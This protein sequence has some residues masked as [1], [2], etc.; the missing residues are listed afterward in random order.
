LTVNDDG[1]ERA[2]ARP[3]TVAVDLGG[4]SAKVAFAVKPG[5]LINQCTIPIEELRQGGD[6]LSGLNRILSDLVAAP[7]VGL[8]PSSVG[9]AVPGIVDEGQGLGVLSLLLGWRDAPI[10]DLVT[11]ACGLPTALRH[12]VGAGAAAEQVIGAARGHANWLFLA[13]GTGLGSTM[14]LDGRAYRG[15]S[16]WGGELAHVVVD[17]AGPTCPCGKRGCLE[18]LASASALTNRYGE[19]SGDPGTVTSREIIRRA[20]NGETAARRV[21]RAALDALVTV[22][23]Q[24]VEMLNPS[25]VVLGGG[26][27]AN[28][29]LVY[30]PFARELPGQVGFVPCPA[31]K[32]A[33]LGVLAGLHGAALG[34]LDVLTRSLPS[35]DYPS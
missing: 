34:G 18:V 9:L 32:P 17:P 23:A 15:A 28:R 6:V 1:A 22:T 10:R 11:D 4:S 20:G 14:M 26:L 12:D 19:L 30:E 27:A 21:L 33:Q 35:P 5:E 2:T 13:L 16:G 31:V 25:L 24:V 7:P 29:E 3:C 8:L